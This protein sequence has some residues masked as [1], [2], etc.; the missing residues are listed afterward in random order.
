MDKKLLPSIT[1]K[2][3]VFITRKYK[4]MKTTKY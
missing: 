2:I 3:A 1:I 4:R